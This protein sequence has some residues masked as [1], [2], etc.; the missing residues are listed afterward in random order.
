MT[1]DKR[2]IESVRSTPAGGPERKLGGG[3]RRTK[4]LRRP[5]IPG[6][7]RDSGRQGESR[8]LSTS[9]WRSGVRNGRPVSDPAGTEALGAAN[10]VA[11]PRC[12][13]ME[14]GASQPA[15]PGT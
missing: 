9:P 15:L 7:P 10:R 8:P 12:V 6:Q 2:S 4:G 3:R 5:T 1:S 14:A 11:R 13:G